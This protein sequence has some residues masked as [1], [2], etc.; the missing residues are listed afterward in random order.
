M[1]IGPL[2]EIN[3]L[4]E[5]MRHAVSC[6]RSGRPCVVDVHIDPGHGRQLRESM[7]ER[8]FAKR[9]E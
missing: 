9:A 6:V 3:Q 8:S 4:S 7:A 1:G 5:A 2:T